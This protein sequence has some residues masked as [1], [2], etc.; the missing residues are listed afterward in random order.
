MLQAKEQKEKKQQIL[1]ILEQKQNNAL[2]DKSIEELQ[3]MLNDI[4]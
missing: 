2:H 3:K 4:N 1:A